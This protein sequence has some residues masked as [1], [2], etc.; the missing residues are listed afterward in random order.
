MRHMSILTPLP[1]QTPLLERL[2]YAIPLFGW[3][4]RDV[5]FGSKDNIYYALVTVLTIWIVVILHWGYPAL[6]IPYLA[7]VP[8]M[9]IILIRIS[10]G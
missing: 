9:F 6:I 7:M 8:A 10:R 1:P 3:M 5:V 4:A 2:F